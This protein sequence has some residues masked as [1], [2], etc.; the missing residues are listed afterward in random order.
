MRYRHNRLG[1]G[2]VLA[3]VAVAALTG[4][5]SDP[6]PSSSTRAADAAT[7]SPAAPSVATTGSPSG[8]G[9]P[10]APATTSSPTAAATAGS[11]STPPAPGAARLG[12]VDVASAFTIASYS[13]DWQ[14][15]KTLDPVERVRPYATDTYLT[16]LR[17]TQQAFPARMTAAQETSVTTIRTAAVDADAPPTTQDEAFV[18]VSYD[19]HLTDHGT[20]ADNRKS[21]SLHL[22][23]VAGEWRVDAVVAAG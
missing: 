2:A 18:S 5:S 4:C 13:Y 19:Q 10:T 14:Q 21:W 7:A 8:T 3:A 22:V 20:P 15:P 1:L 16:T 6:A 9:S 12:P 11:P 17:P 23:Q